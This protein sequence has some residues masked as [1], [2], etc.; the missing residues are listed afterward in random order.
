MA[1]LED[2]K[3]TSYHR[4]KSAL[5]V[6]IEQF[7]NPPAELKEKNELALLAYIGC[8]AS[9]EAGLQKYRDKATS[10]KT[11]QYAAEEGDSST[12]R[13]NL[14]LA[15]QPCPVP[16]T[17]GKKAEAPDRVEAHHIIPS[18]DNRFTLAATLR[19]R[20]ARAKVRIDDSDNGVWLPKTKRDRIPSTPHA[21]PHRNIHREGYYRFLT[22][23]FSTEKNKIMFRTKLNTVRNMLRNG[24]IPDW[25]MLPKH[26]LPD[27]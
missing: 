13:Q 19:A 3:G 12:L 1:Q 20:L 23:L 7:G 17:P 11:S 25:V 24:D 21:V 2:L 9:V 27:D 10:W 15:G 4:Q 6:T 14:A 8:L 22:G 16:T 5:D 26:M 18:G